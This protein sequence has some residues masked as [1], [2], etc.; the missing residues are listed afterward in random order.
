MK[1]F[2]I[3]FLAFVGMAAL[4]P[5][6]VI[7]GPNRQYTWTVASTATTGQQGSYIALIGQR[8]PIPST[9]SLQSV[10]SGTAPGACTF[11][12]EGSNDAATWVGLDAGGVSCTASGIEYISNKPV[13]F[14]RVNLATFTPG[15]T[16]T[17]VKFNYTGGTSTGTG[18]PSTV[19]AAIA[20]GGT[21]ATTAPAALTNLG[22]APLSSPSFTG[23]PALPTGTTFNSNA[24]TSACT[25]ALGTSGATIPLLSTA[26]TWTLAQTF[27]VLMQLSLGANVA[28]GQVLSWNS[29]SGI[30][31]GSAG[32][33]FFGNGTQGSNSG[34][35]NA[36]SFQAGSGA[37]LST[38]AT[39]LALSNAAPIAWSSTSG[40]TGTKDSGIDRSAAGVLE[41][42]NG[43]AGNANGSLKAANLTVASLNQ[44]AASSTGGTCAMSTSTSCTITL[45]HTFTTPVCIATQQ[46]AT[47]TGG[48]VGCTVSGTTV[49]IT[50]AVA[51]SETWGALVFGNPN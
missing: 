7:L 8:G 33:L 27:S 18:F 51:N 40:Y 36:T 50:S 34:T 46:S 19:P 37:N 45:G 9:Y 42:N 44:S 20:S 28:T 25:T 38:G 5:A 35:L 10:V 39:T 26:N 47:L 22:A 29:D 13:T 21:G 31:R 32:T 17:V 12:L 48:S 49:T 6:Q 24:L 23:T 30:S 16:T 41:I 4:A 2:V 11:S 43:A 15:D 3:A 14:V 1:N